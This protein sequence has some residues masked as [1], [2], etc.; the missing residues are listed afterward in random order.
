[1]ENNVVEQ[2]KGKNLVVVILVILL[3]SACGFICYD[4]FLKKDDSSQKDCNCPICNDS[5]ASN[6]TMKNESGK[7]IVKRNGIAK[8]ESVPSDIVGK[9]QNKSGDYYKL[10][11]DGSAEINSNTGCS[12]DCD[13]SDNSSLIKSS[14]LTFQLSFV[15]DEHIIVEFY[16]NS[17]D[18]MYVPGGFLF[19][20]KLNGSYRFM[21]ADGTPATNACEQE[22]MFEKK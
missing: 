2:N 7:I 8:L 13:S 3:L 12:G 19:G 14:E 17:K 1:M 16:L 5:S 4:K 20:D 11:S 22:Q 18:H 15:D 21:L 10:N 6:D 9:Y